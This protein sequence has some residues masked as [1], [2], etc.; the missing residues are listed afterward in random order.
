MSLD[1]DSG[2]FRWRPAFHD[3][4][5]K[6]VLGKTGR[7]DG[8]DLLALLLARPETAEFVTAKLWRE[9]VSPSPDAAEVRRLAALWRDARYEIKPL[10][11]ALLL[12]PAFWAED[13]RQSL[14]KSPVDLVVGTMR[15]YQMRPMDMRPAVVACAALGQNVFSP[16]NV[17]GWPGGEAWIN[18]A[19]LLG[20]K[21]W[22]ERTFRGGDNLEAMRAMNDYEQR[23]ELARA[24]V[25]E[26]AYQLK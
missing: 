11:R 23:A 7:F 22:L 24:A 8:D 14:I 25:S 15:T 17:K 5:E 18:A 26:A 1:R 16:P 2:E 4:G 20:R 21:Q 12:A 3:R 6:T 19:T 9:F 13:N 10:M